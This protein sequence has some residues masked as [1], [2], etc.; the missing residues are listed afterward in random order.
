MLYIPKIYDYLKVLTDE[1]VKDFVAIKFGEYFNSIIKEK[2]LRKVAKLLYIFL[3]K[4]EKYV[5]SN[6]SGN[7]IHR[8]N[9]E[10]LNL[11]IF[12]SR[13]TTD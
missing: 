11:F 5:E 13:I 3:T 12:W 7:C 10:I 1:K 2:S 9:V 8:Y 4:E 6:S